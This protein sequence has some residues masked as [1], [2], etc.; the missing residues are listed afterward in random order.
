MYFDSFDYEAFKDNIYGSSSRMKIRYRWYSHFKDEENGKLEFKFKRNVFGWKKR[1]QI[2]NLKINSK[3]Q[4]KSLQE[5]IKKNLPSYER[6]IFESNCQPK[7]VNQY[8][9]EYYENYNREFRVTVDTSHKI[10]DQRFYKKVNLTNKAL[11]QK[12]IIV[13][14]KFDRNNSHLSKM[15]LKTLPF[16]ISRSSKY[17]NSIRSVSGI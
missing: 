16:R 5:T 15:M 11:I 14:F 8:K 4:L 3:L 17:I 12:Y 10:Y 7:I 2:S 9:R 6:V 13:E 1:F